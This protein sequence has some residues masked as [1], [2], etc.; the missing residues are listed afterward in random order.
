MRILQLTKF[1]PPY[2][3]GMETVVFDITERLNRRGHTAD[4]LCSNTN[5]S[6]V[7]EQAASGYRITRAANFGRILSTSIAPAI[8]WHLLKQRTAYDLIH[9]H[10]PDPLTAAA[11][12][13]ARPRSRIIVH[14]HSDVVAQRRAL[15]FYLPLQ[16]WL[17]RRAD[18]VIATSPPY[19]EG[20]PWLRKVQDK[21][22]VV[23]L[24]TDVRASSIIGQNNEEAV[25]IK[26]AAL[27]LRSR[28]RNRPIVFSLGR[29]AYYKGFDVLI[30]AARKISSDAVVI[31][32][33]GGELLETHRKKVE[34]LG[35]QDRID[36]IGPVPSD[37]LPVYYAAADLFCLPSVARSE[38]FGVVLIE[39]MA[40]GVPV[41]T[42]NIPGSGVPWVNSH[43][44]SGLNVAP[45][46][47]TALATAIDAVTQNPELRARLR[48]GARQRYLNNFTADKMVDGIEAVYA[49][50]GRPR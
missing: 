16:N 4:V 28:Y 26:Q 47:S 23:P 14:W 34:D 8:I 39:A 18:A 9:I 2:Q 3:G 5:R 41:I 50:I 38:A 37:M 12:F 49:T 35:L 45:G 48:C 7:V 33:G 24:G 20:S 6:T 1:Y 46:D 21:V 31:V 36:F 29:M 27:E 11:L 22:F 10:M 43:N 17:L 19:L 32:G 40:M 30:D 42:T 13:L 25:A 15:T 44:I